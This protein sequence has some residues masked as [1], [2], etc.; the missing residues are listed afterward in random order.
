ML[1]FSKHQGAI[2]GDFGQVSAISI[3][4]R[5]CVLWERIFCR[6]CTRRMRSFLCVLGMCE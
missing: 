4:T 6:R 2:R 3:L 5:R 1:D